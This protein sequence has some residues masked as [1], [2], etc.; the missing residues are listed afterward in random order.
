MERALDP[1]LQ[2]PER[3]DF[4]YAM[5][6]RNDLCQRQLLSIR[7]MRTANPQVSMLAAVM[8]GN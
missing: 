6:T 8:R 1:P 5:E 2:R 3:Q 4:H 7:E